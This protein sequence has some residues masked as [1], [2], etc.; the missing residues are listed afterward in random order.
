[1]NNCVFKVFA[2]AKTSVRTVRCSLFTI[3][4]PPPSFLGAFRVRS[5]PCPFS[6]A[7][8]P[9]SGEAFSP[10]I[11]GN[12]DFM[13]ER[14]F[15][16]NLA[17]RVHYHRAVSNFNRLSN[18]S[19]MSKDKK[20]KCCCKGG[21]SVNVKPLGDRVLLKRCECAEEI[22]GGII[23]PDS[24]KEKPMEAKVVALG[25]GKVEDGKK[26][27]FNVEVGDKVLIGKYSGTEVK[28]DDVAYILVR[29]DEILAV[30]G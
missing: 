15:S 11:R 26:V 6:R 16:G 23:I 17:R 19:Y 20:E 30:L 2:R 14:G 5:V 3:H 12:V 1:M 18:H 8:V 7:G 9:A 13:R 24:A 25:T 10:K 21:C 4:Y 29:E 22:K 27:E 28:I